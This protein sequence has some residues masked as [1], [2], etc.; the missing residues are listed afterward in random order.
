MPRSMAHPDYVYTP[1]T[2]EVRAKLSLVHKSRLGIPPDCVRIYGIH[3]PNEMEQP[4]RSYA[5]WMNQKKGID[6]ARRFIRKALEEG[7][8][9]RPAPHKFKVTDRRY[10]YRPWPVTVEKRIAKLKQGLGEPDGPVLYGIC[11]TAAYRADNFHYLTAVRERVGLQAARWIICSAWE[12][13]WPV[14][15][16]SRRADGLIDTDLV[17]ALQDEG[18]TLAEI[19]TFLG[20]R[21]HSLKAQLRARR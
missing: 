5:S 9:R 19:A 13:G 14:E 4:L 21:L 20:I 8:V 7:R 15:K 12:A 18:A 11:V 17:R 6:A 16:L 2:P 3:V 10:L 1:R